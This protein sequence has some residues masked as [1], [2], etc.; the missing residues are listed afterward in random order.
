M[1]QK[2]FNQSMKNI[3]IAERKEFLLQLIHSINE[4][5]NRAKWRAAFALDP[6]M[7]SRSKQ[8]FGFRSIAAP[9]HIPELEE[10]LDKLANMVENVKF[11]TGIIRNRLQDKLRKEIKEIYNDSKLF[12]P[13]D[14]TSNF[15]K[16]EVEAY[17]KLLERDIT[18][19][20]MKTNDAKVEEIEQEAIEIATELELQDR[21]FKTSKR[22]A[23]INLK[24]HK[25]LFREK[26]PTRL[27]NPTKSEIGKVSKQKLSKVIAV[28][29]KQT[30]YNQWINTNATTKWFREQPNKQRLHF[31]KGDVEA[32]YPSISQELLTNALNWASTFTPISEEDRR[33]IL[34]SQKSLLYFKDSAWVKKENPEFNIGM[35]SFDGAECCDVVGLYLLSQMQDLQINIG[36]Y[37][38]DLLSTSSLTKRQNELVKQKI[39]RIFSANGLK[40][41][42]FEV[43]RKQVDFLNVTMDLET[44]THKAFKKDNDHPSYVHSDSNHPPAV[45]KAIPSGINRMLSDLA[46]NEELFEETAPTYQEALRSAGYSYKLSYQP[47]LEVE[48]EAGQQPR[49]KNRKRNVCWFNPPFGKNVVTN[50]PRL[51]MSIIAECFPPGHV[52]RSSFNKSNIKVSYRTTTNLAQILSKHNNKVLSKARPEVVNEGCNCQANRKEECPLPGKCLTKGLVYKAEVTATVEPPP[53]S[54]APPTITTKTYGGLTVNTFKKR[55]YGH[56]ADMRNPDQTKG[57]TLSKYVW[58]LKNANTAFTIAWSILDRGRG[59]NI[60]SKSCRLCLLEKWHI[61]FNKPATTLNKRS[62]LFS[63]CRHRR[64]LVLVPPPRVRAPQ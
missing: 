36:I 56:T 26:V 39:S 16:L 29:R 10:L 23:T 47:R 32:F 57:T 14:K 9:P 8:T 61:M 13:A 19:D 51:F 24:D 44:G 27:L 11:K 54:T 30:G 5:I 20:Y 59:Y 45:I 15:Y 12:I 53:N 35:G 25:P 55:H 1:E 42:D 52:L 62:E 3:P 17:E 60:T 50:I 38:D 34:H 21:I 7:K 28:V 37:R 2:T 22:Q 49:R 48:G 33:I 4:F 64:K 46:S 31:I 58:E 6:E 18:K 41:T 40:I 43:N 63:S